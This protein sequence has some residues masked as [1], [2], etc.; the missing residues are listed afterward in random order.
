MFWVCPY[1]RTVAYEGSY[2]LRHL[3]KHEPAIR[4]LIR[5]NFLKTIALTMA[6]K[7]ESDKE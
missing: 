1:C 6:V 5:D 4:K 7:L 3:A 2:K